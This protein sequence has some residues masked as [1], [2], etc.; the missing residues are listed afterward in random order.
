MKEANQGV[1]A[2]LVL[3]R[4]RLNDNLKGISIGSIRPIASYRCYEVFVIRVPKTVE[5][6]EKLP[7]FGNWGATRL[8]AS[9]LKRQF[10][11]PKRQVE[12]NSHPC[13]AQ[14]SFSTGSVVYETL[15]YS[16]KTLSF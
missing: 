6:V 12:Q 16:T 8:S 5:R 3:P 14:P 15:K 10:C 1:K 4:C 11:L 9:D 2:C 13:A 7:N